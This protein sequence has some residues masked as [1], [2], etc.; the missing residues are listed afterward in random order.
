MADPKKNTRELPV[1]DLH[2][3]LD[4]L[5]KAL[6]SLRVRKVTDVVENPA[7]FKE[8]RRR[9]AQIKA[10][11]QERAAKKPAPAS[12]AKPARAVKASTSAPGASADKA[13]DK[14]AKAGPRK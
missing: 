3:E 13:S 4:G 10:A 14:P 12:A 1:E 11:L 2:K 7:A 8:H 6:F 5:V 9:I